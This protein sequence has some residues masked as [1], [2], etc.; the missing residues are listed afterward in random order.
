MSMPTGTALKGLSRGSARGPLPHLITLSS[1]AA[2]KYMIVCD[3]SQKPL[4]YFHL[5]HSMGITNA[6]VFTKSE[7][8]AGLFERTHNNRSERKSVLE[9]FR[10]QKIDILSHTLLNCAVH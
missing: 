4:V 8:A 1:L 7:S 5:I 3:A 6:L 10:A 2:E 9:K